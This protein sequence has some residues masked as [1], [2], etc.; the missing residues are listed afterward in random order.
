MQTIIDG[1]VYDTQ[2]A[3]EV[4]AV[5]SLRM[6]CMLTI[7]HIGTIPAPEPLNKPQGSSTLYRTPSD[8]FF[9]WI[10]IQFAYPA[11]GTSF[12]VDTLYPLSD[13][14]TKD[15]LIGHQKVEELLTLFPDAV[16]EA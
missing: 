3:T 14:D 4:T 12:S 11:H 15:W 6:D 16:A 13:E 7:E 2:K 1:L 8:R 5:D 10:H 9:L